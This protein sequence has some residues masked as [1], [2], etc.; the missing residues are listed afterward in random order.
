MRRIKPPVQGSNQAI[1]GGKEG[2][3]NVLRQN[4]EIYREKTPE[5]T[6][7]LLM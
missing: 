1:F 4:G 5:S 3:G 6:K 7:I 2:K